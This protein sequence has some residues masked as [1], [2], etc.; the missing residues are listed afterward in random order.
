[1]NPRANRPVPAVVAA[2]A[3]AAVAFVLYARTACPGAFWQDSG[4]Y[5]RSVYTLGNCYPPGYP[6]YLS[7]GHLWTCLPGLNPIYGLNLFSAFA[8]AGAALFVAL[9]ALRLLA[10]GPFAAAGAA[11]ASLL[12]TAAPA[13]WAQATV[14]EV[15][16]LNLALAAATMWLLLRWGDAPEDR[17]PLYAAAFVYGLAAGTHP[18]Q[19]AFLPAYA[20]FVLWVG[21]RRLGLPALALIAAFFAAA[22]SA[23]LYLPIRSA[24]GVLPDWGL[25]RLL[26][27]F[28]AHLTAKMYHRDQFHVTAPL[29][30]AR[31]R[32]AADVF[33]S[34][35]GWAGVAAG[36]LG[37]AWLWARRPRG[38]VLI[39]GAG[40]AA[41]AF[42][43]VYYSANWRTWYA[44]WYMAW[45][46]AAGAAAAWVSGL[47]GRRRPWLGNVAAAA[48]VC[49][50]ALPVF[51]RY[52]PAD[53]SAYR[54]GETAA[55]GF[56]RPL[57]PRATFIMS[58]EGSAVFGPVQ[59]LVTGA[60]SRPD[61]R[62]VDG[63]GCRQFQDFMAMTLTA[64]RAPYETV[65]PEEYVAAFMSLTAGRTRDFYCLYPFPAAFSY[66]YRF[67]PRG[68][69]LRIVR[70]GET[71]PARDWWAVCWPADFRG[72]EGPYLDYWTA[73][74]YGV[75]YTGRARQL[76][77]A[78]DA[79][80]A[81]PFLAAA[82]RI[83]GR[84][85]MVQYNLGVVA[86]EGGDDD[87]ALAHYRR[88]LALDPTF[89]EPRRRM[90]EVYRRLG[91]EGEA[92][93]VEA[94]LNAL[95]PTGREPA[96]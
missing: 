34:Q 51:F 36:L 12:F 1:M 8:A 72:V 37:S 11:V 84:S 45:S 40:A 48:A 74:Y 10:P 23:Y 4:I 88:A 3:A 17:R 93:R 62:F 68:M 19:A 75:A 15:Y 66:G 42:I 94:D 96:R 69:T 13:V 21:R 43:L 86:A 89:A 95:Y 26:P 70:P 9:I 25:T 33:Q 80:G 64:R 38:A 55:R 35:F 77:A 59:A 92:R 73:T 49:A 60:R 2:F 5:F 52:G 79:A 7:A 6:V 29:L 14:A 63:T 78:G 30:W 28:W 58:P 22:F 47:A 50:A 16:A 41:A 53:L 57:G 46:L 18:E 83:G 65:P 91:R 44:P 71:T 67:E 39:F 85:E 87:G 76:L 32:M 31:I 27:N 54:W 20:A 81:A 56:F 82:D 61:V 90:A 24:T